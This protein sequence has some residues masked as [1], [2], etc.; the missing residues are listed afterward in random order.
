[1]HVKQPPFIGSTSCCHPVLEAVVPLAFGCPVPTVEANTRGIISEAVLAGGS[2]PARILPLGF[3][4]QLHVEPASVGHPYAVR[5]RIL[6]GDRA[7]WAGVS[8]HVIPALPSEPGELTKEMR[9]H[10]EVPRL[11]LHELHALDRHGPAGG[12]TGGREAVLQ[13]QPRRGPVAEVPDGGDE[14]DE[15]EHDEGGDE[16]PVQHE[17]ILREHRVLVG[18]TSGLPSLPERIPPRHHPVE[19]VLPL[20]GRVSRVVP[21]LRVVPLPVEDVRHHPPRRRAAD[22]AR[23]RRPPG[24]RQRQRIPVVRRP[25]NTLLQ[26]LFR[27]EGAAAVAAVRVLQGGQVLPERLLSW[28]TAQPSCCG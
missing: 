20:P 8:R 9:S 6:E 28:R 10:P 1:M 19:P 12:A 2:R 26:V 13:D 3:G 24:Q 5:P 25:A 18:R 4:R 15:E 22:Q 21:V 11:Q 23:P 7:H 14:G 27:F 17:N 16:Q